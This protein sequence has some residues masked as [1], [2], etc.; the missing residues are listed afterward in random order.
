MLWMDAAGDATQAQAVKDM[1]CY[2]TG[3]VPWS[4]RVELGSLDGHRQQRAQERLA[5]DV[6]P[7]PVLQTT[8]VHS[9]S[10]SRPCCNDLSEAASQRTRARAASARRCGTHLGYGVLLDESQQP[11]VQV[12]VRL[13]QVIRQ[14]PGRPAAVRKRPL[15]VVDHGG[16]II[17]LG[18]GWLSVG[19]WGAGPHAGRAPADVR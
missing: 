10:S 3:R 1:D 5:A 7:G 8:L 4:H 13:H 12:Q 15:S 9:F 17:A 19:R 14:R 18:R 16:R 11:V 6:I 2:R